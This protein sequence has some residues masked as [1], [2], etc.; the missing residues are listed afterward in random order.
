MQDQQKASRILR[1]EERAVI[2]AML[3]NEASSTLRANLDSTPVRD[4]HDGGMGGLRFLRRGKRHRASTVA[5]AQFNDDDGV[6]VS[7]E[8][9]AD[10]E[11]ELFELDI[12]KVDFSPLRRFPHPKDLSNFDK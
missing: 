8:L 2:L 7:I 3:P 12:W 10:E 5:E 4:L 11:G 9:N 6:L 1:E